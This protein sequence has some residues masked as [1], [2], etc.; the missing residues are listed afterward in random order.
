MNFAETE[1]TEL[2]QRFNDILPKEI[3]AFLNTDGGTVYIGVNDDGT[4]CGVQNLDETLKK[5]ADILENQILPDP[6]SFVELGTKFVEGQH[7]IE[8]KIQ[9]GDGLFYIKKY[10]R[11]SQGCFIRVGSTS[12]PMTEEQ[13]VAVHN[14]YLDSKV[15]ITEIASR[16]ENPTFRYLKLLLTEKG[17]TINE[18]AFVRNFNLL[19]RDGSYN[20]M[21]ELLADKNDVSIKVV[22]FKGKSK[23]DGIALRNEYGE[24]C[25]VVAMKQAF[26]YCADVINETRVSFSN[27]V[28]N[29]QK[30]FDRDAFREAWFNACLHN[31]W[32]DGTPPAIYIYTDR[33]EIIS[34]GGLPPNLSKEDFFRG[35]SKPVN[36]ELAKLFIRLDL[37]EQTGYGVP[38][39]AGKYGEN[40]FEFLDFFLRV[41]I[42]FAFELENEEAQVSP[43]TGEKVREKTWEKIVKAISENPSVT[44]AALAEMLNISVK[45]VEWQFR[46]LKKKN[47]IRRIGADKGGHWEVIDA[48]QGAADEN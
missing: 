30:L 31:N 6:R 3:V 10:G 1:K 13:I 43:K 9:K 41:T 22:R 45:G 4:V 18:A 8:V 17:F 33:M 44:T 48:N 35:V 38:L 7:V 32:A 28:R 40:A 15:K 14:K 23:A 5:I 29:N 36:E 21:A 42:P 47:I 19:T 20:K 27:G 46:Q 25:L 37:M 2:K 12:R 11:S 26:D 39:V 24:K 34:T 16:I